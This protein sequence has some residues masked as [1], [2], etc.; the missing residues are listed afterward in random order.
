[1]AVWL[2]AQ[3]EFVLN[4]LCRIRDGCQSFPPMRASPM[5]LQGECRRSSRQRVSIPDRSRIA[6]LGLFDYPPRYMPRRFHDVQ[7]GTFE[8]GNGEP[9]EVV[10]FKDAGYVDRG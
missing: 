7:V 5:I 9:F 1:M 8:P 4:A 2:E 6:G 10:G 3:Q